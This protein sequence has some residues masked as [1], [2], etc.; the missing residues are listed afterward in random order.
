MSK[1]DPLK[2]AL[3]R[4]YLTQQSCSIPETPY[5][6]Q[7]PLLMP[8]CLED[9][10]EFDRRVKHAGLLWLQNRDFR[11]FNLL[12]ITHLD[13]NLSYVFQRP[14]FPGDTGFTMTG[15]EQ[16]LIETGEHLPPYPI[17]FMESIEPLDALS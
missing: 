1:V 4:L 9:L 16:A 8:D 10:E 6:W 11:P 17:V 7:C 13:A 2:L 3:R 12:V 5:Q 14:Q 15:I